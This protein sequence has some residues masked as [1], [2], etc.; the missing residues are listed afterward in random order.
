MTRSLTCPTRQ[1]DRSK[2]G[3]RIVTVIGDS[4]VFY[5]QASARCST[6]PAAGRDAENRASWAATPMGVWLC[7]GHPP[8]RLV[9]GAAVRE[10]SRHGPR[11]LVGQARMGHVTILQADPTDRNSVQRGDISHQ[12]RCVHRRDSRM[13][14]RQHPRVR[15]RPRRWV[16]RRR[17]VAVVQQSERTSGCLVPAWAWIDPFSPRGSSRGQGVA[18]SVHRR[19]PRSSCSRG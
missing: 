2:P 14:K 16:R 8:T 10:R 19:Q 9:L 17:V 18:Q 4:N 3:D 6:R 12:C 7:P 11:S 15:C 5:R 1:L 13:T